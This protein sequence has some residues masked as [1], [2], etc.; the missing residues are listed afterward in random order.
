MSR[1]RRGFSLFSLNPPLPIA[2]G[3][4]L[5]YHSVRRYIASRNSWRGGSAVSETQPMS[6]AMY[7]A[8]LA[9]AEPGHG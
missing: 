4:D 7:Y 6:E 9:L 3:G 5:C 2:R 8:L 1:A